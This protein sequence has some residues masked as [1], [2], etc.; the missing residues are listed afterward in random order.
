MAGRQD[1]NVGGG[2]MDPELALKDR[3]DLVHAGDKEASKFAPRQEDYDP[4]SE[5][6]EGSSGEKAAT[7]AATAQ[8]EAGSTGTHDSIAAST[9]AGVKAATQGK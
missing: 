8:R 7:A 3:V 6:A 5:H 2:G 4:T 1:H 9:A